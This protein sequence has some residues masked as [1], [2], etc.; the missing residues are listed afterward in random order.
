MLKLTQRKAE[1]LEF[2]RVATV[3]DGRPPTQM[4]IAA[5]FGF[6]QTAARDHLLAL[7]Q[8]GY[9]EFEPRSARGT[10]LLQTNSEPATP[11]QLPV[12][13][14]IAAG[15]PILSSENIDRYERVDP[16][17][18]HPRAHFLLE[19]QGWSMR[20]ADIYDGDLVAIH[21]TLD[22]APREIVAVQIQDR[23]TGEYE[24]TLKQYTRDGPIVVLISANDDQESFKPIRLDPKQD[25][26]QIEGVLSGH[27]RKR[28]SAS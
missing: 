12:I 15:V 2:I 17:L 10:R 5:E 22:A 28:R 1:I 25:F 20:N 26:F 21:Q 11:F 3:A 23:L 27:I 19:V 16:G 13:G 8:K 6:R 18:F 24:L 9:I 14:R 4:G 7:A